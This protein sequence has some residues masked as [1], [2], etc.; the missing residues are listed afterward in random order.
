MYLN[1]KD[2]MQEEYRTL[3]ALYSALLE[4]DSYLIRREAFSLDRIVKVIESRSRDLA[5][6]E[7]E[8]RKIT[9]NA[10]MRE[11]VRKSED[12]EMEKLYTNIVKLIDRVQFQRD[13]NDALI[14]QGLFFTGQMLRALNPG[15][16]AVT[17]NAMGKNN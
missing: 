11:I 12:R 9:K 1:L 5:K 17:Y 15:R 6:C 10:S 4:Q 2:I 8:R 3:D 14:K 13:T 16:K 7:I